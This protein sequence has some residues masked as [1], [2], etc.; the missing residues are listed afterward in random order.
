MTGLTEITNLN[1]QPEKH[2][3]RSYRNHAF[4]IAGLPLVTF[5]IH[6]LEIIITGQ[7]RAEALLARAMPPPA[8][9]EGQ[10]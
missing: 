6:Q 3:D 1:H 4:I 8:G 7:V 5:V 10:V 2:H 9:I